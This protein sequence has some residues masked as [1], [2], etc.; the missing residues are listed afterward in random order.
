MFLDIIRELKFE[1]VFSI[2]FGIILGMD[3]NLLMSISMKDYKV[4]YKEKY[5]DF[6]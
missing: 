5:N 3:W 2:I 4:C 1:V 6:K